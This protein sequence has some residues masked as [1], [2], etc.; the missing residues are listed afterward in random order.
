[1]KRYF[2]LALWFKENENIQLK[3]LKITFSKFP[4]NFLSVVIDLK[5]KDVGT[6][7]LLVDLRRY[8]VNKTFL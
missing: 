7:H 2:G 8:G 6:F 3:T 4:N 1:M 5:V